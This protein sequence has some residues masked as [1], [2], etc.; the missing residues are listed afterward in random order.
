MAC[1]PWS[2]HWWEDL[3][4][5]SEHSHQLIHGQEEVCS[6]CW[7]DRRAI[8]FNG[9]QQK[10][11][12]DIAWIEV[13]LSINITQTL[14]VA[15]KLFTFYKITIGLGQQAILLLIKI[16]VDKGKLT[17][18][19]SL[20]SWHFLFSLYLHFLWLNK[21]ARKQNLSHTSRQNETH[22]MLGKGDCLPQIT[23]IT[24]S[25]ITWNHWHSLPLPWSVWISW[26]GI[27]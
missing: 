13:T 7:N 23:T 10:N 26:K 27:I 15:A 24:I 11:L 25:T 8:Q 1:R 17:A 12:R 22:N 4:G 3:S 21:N 18:I 9:G 5:K 19:V 6:L 14:M 16:N 20:W 2:T